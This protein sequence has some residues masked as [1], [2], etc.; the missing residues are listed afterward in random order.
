MSAFPIG[1]KNLAEQVI[2]FVADLEGLTSEECKKLN[3]KGKA[4]DTLLTVIDDGK[5]TLANYFTD[6]FIQE[7]AGDQGKK[8]LEARVKWLT[9]TCLNPLTINDEKSHR[10]II[11]ES[12]RIGINSP[13]MIDHLVQTLEESKDFEL[14]MQAASFL[15][16][17][18]L[19][20]ESDDEQVILALIKYAAS[21]D[22]TGHGDFKSYVEMV[23]S[24]LSRRG[25]AIYPA[26]E[27]AL[28]DP[29]LAV[30]EFGVVILR[31]LNIPPEEKLIYLKKALHHQSARVRIGAL[32][33]LHD[34]FRGEETLMNDFLA[35]YES[36]QSMEGETEEDIG[37]FQHLASRSIAERITEIDQIEPIANNSDPDI[38]IGVDGLLENDHFAANEIRPFILKA[39]NDGDPYVSSYILWYIRYL[40]HRSDIITTPECLPTLIKLLEDDN[41]AIC[42]NTVFFLGELGPAA[43]EALP[44]LNAMLTSNASQPK[45]EIYEAILKIDPKLADRQNR[46]EQP[47]QFNKRIS[48]GIALAPTIAGLTTNPQASPPPVYLD[49]MLSVFATKPPFA[50]EDEGS[51]FALYVKPAAV[52]GNKDQSSFGVATG[53]ITGGDLETSRFRVGKH[54]VTPSYEVSGGVDPIAIGSA[55]TKGNANSPFGMWEGSLL[56]GAS[57]DHQ[58]QVQVGVN[59]FEQSVTF[60]EGD[61]TADFVTSINPT[62]RAG[63]RF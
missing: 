56:F 36:T 17:N 18:L 51:H 15:I 6:E 63:Y 58:W 23:L 22:F 52:V 33:E 14:Q 16:T 2:H 24:L 43:Q 11:R 40:S 34:S 61:A 25:V 3:I 42:M 49:V 28:E 59:P 29:N 38:R 50:L 54:T 44:K 46:Y 47:L 60:E 41:M 37:S 39:L 31:T 30:R 21:T 55:L 5:K 26:L 4:A 53:L 1:D 48:T 57:V 8:A 7:L 19:M 35:E 27:Q 10:I 45:K 32:L 13:E 9:A 20:T 62:V 12:E